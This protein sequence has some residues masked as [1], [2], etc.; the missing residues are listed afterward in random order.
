MEVLPESVA[1]KRP[2]E[3]EGPAAGDFGRMYLDDRRQAWGYEDSPAQALPIA[4]PFRAGRYVILQHVGHGAM[5]NVY[6]AYDPD[7]DRKV[8]VKVL[9]DSGRPLPASLVREAKAMA[10][11]THPHVVA[12][13]DVGTCDRGVFV[14]MEFVEGVTLRTWLKA[15]ARSWREAL[16]VF[17]RAGEGLAAAHAGGVVHHDFKPDNVLIG[18]DGAV[19]KVV[20]FGLARVALGTAAAV[21]GE[22]SDTGSRAATTLAAT[23]IS[24]HGPSGLSAGSVRGADAVTQASERGPV[25][26]LAYMAPERHAQ[27]PA[28]AR[29]DQFSFCVALYEALYHQRPFAGTDVASLRHAVL[30][31]APIDPPKGSSVPLRIAAALR[32][33]LARAPEDRFPTMT[34]LLAALAEPRRRRL[35]WALSAGL[36]GAASAAMLAARSSEDRCATITSEADSWWQTNAVDAPPEV[37]EREAAWAG[38]VQATCA[39]GMRGELAADL[40][41]AREACLGE[42]WALTRALVETAA[43]VPAQRE[44]LWAEVPDG[45]QCDDPAV[46]V[47]VPAP[48]FAQRG[49]VAD[50]R[51]GL[52]QVAADEVAGAYAPAQARLTELL[53]RAEALGYAPVLAEALYQRGRLEHYSGESASGSLLAAIDAAEANRHDRVAADAWGFLAEVAALGRRPEFADWDRRAQAARSRLFAG[54]RTGSATGGGQ[55]VH[56]A[57]ARGLG[58]LQAGD[59]AGAAEAFRGALAEPGLHPLMRAKLQLNL[60]VVQDGEAQEAAWQAALAAYEDPRISAPHRAQAR[61]ERGESLFWRERYAEASD[62]FAAGAALLAA[63]P[64][65]TPQRHAALRMAYRGVAIGEVIAFDLDGASAAI[66]AAERATQDGHLPADPGLAEVAFEVHLLAGRADEARRVAEAAV[67]LLRAQNA[68]PADRAMAHARLGEALL[69]SGETDAASRAYATALAVV[70]EAALPQPDDTAAYAYKGLGLRALRDGANKD[71]ARTLEQA[72]ALWQATPC[73]CRDEAEARLALAVAYTRLGDPR[74][75]GMRAAADEFFTRRGAG[76]EGHRG[77]LERWLIGG[78]RRRA[79]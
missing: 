64:D 37:A 8:A 53:N 28:D 29:S 51:E 33:G 58:A 35:H 40:R 56:P 76:A 25:G 6:A 73:E 46:L 68:P 72:T 34:A 11:L 77:R 23:A 67:A 39:A 30:H 10:K 78:E 21:S 59:R 27:R 70:D 63:L 18:G 38:R 2:G 45:A 61:I 42:Q 49:E 12:V 65:P 4:E 22:L 52:A 75:P 9:R 20:D 31:E 44:A 24:P 66:A 57:I 16:A 71:A 55:Q 36:I 7:L 62:E 32:R 47:A 79:L 3:D 19:V 15:Q 43:R 69:W 60:A 41:L 54:S 26:T 50:I 14:A 74:G 17:T 48:E 13:H 1:R 5:G